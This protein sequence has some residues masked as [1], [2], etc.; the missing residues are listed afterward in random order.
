M[1]YI[2]ALPIGW[3]MCSSA[4]VGD[5]AVLAKCIL[6]ERLEGVEV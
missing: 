3:E 2:Q 1:K 6:L 4:G 5:R